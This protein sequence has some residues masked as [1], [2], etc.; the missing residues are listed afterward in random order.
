MPQQVRARQTRDTILNAAA[1][2][3]DSQGFDAATIGDIVKASGTTK[4]ALY[5]HFESKEALAKAIIEEQE[6]WLS[7]V[8]ADTDHPLQEV[9]DI[10]F[11]FSAAL[12]NDPRLRASIRLTVERGTF[13]EPQ[14]D[15]YQSWE[16][17]V[18][19]R[20]QK[21]KKLGHVQARW[22]P[23]K[24]AQTVT[25]AVTGLQLASEVASGR[26]DL[27]KRL[28]TFWDA[29]LPGIVEPDYLAEL[30]VRPPRRRPAEAG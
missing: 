3:F 27:D 12:R 11:V 4:G 7:A 26:Q 5:F 6:A 30:R 8:P 10:S 16:A 22:S 18:A 29:L 19:T 25:G 1:M 28:E 21:A 17:V 15:A 24:L 14:P 2:V 20:I 23:A 13:H 9:I